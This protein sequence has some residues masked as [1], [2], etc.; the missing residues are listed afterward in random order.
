MVIQ[1]R[2]VSSGDVALIRRL[3]A[4]HP[5]WHRTR[6]SR[7]LCTL[8]QWRNAKGRLKDMA[9]RSLLLKLERAGHITLPPRRRPANNHLR[10]RS[11][12]DLAH[13]AAPVEAALGELM[14]INVG[15]AH[16][17]EH[18][19]LFESVLSRYHYLGY[20]GTVGENVKYLAFDRDGH[21]LACVLFGSAAWTVAP[22]DAFIGWD[23]GSRR[24]HL[25]LVTN[26]MR[27][28]ILPWV[29]VSHLASHVLGRVARRLSGDWRERYGHPIVLL[30]TFVERGRFA[31]TCYRA[32]NWTCVGQTTGRTR[33]DCEHAIRT[34]VKD[35]YLYPLTKAFRKELCADG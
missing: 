25:H 24:R 27:F 15:P 17:P 20:T 10:N 6:L 28:L 13:H 12:R 4:E 34:P 35:V 8:W 22:R 9:C 11:C 30:E 32:A 2:C 26:N 3:I 23:E 1:G 16:E 31:G 19:A 29:R 33:N 7:H 5:S 21:L 18:R 14:P